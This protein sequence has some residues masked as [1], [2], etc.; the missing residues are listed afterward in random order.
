MPDG[1]PFG[2]ARRTLTVDANAAKAFTS[3]IDKE[4]AFAWQQLPMEELD[5]FLAQQRIPA[6]SVPAAAASAAYT[7]QA[8]SQQAA[9]PPPYAAVPPPQAAPAY[10]PMSHAQY[11]RSSE[12]SSRLLGGNIFPFASYRNNHRFSYNKESVAALYAQPWSMQRAPVDRGNFHRPNELS[13]FMVAATRLGMK[14][15]GDQRS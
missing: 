2:K 6:P 10:V 11:L 9:V 5:T 14:A 7:A 12:T 8:P 15:F 13:E 4:K 1:V 3:A